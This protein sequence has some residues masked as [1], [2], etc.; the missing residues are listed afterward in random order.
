M[1]INV[2]LTV[3]LLGMI[4]MLVYGQQEISEDC[5]T[6]PN[7]KNPKKCCKMPNIKPPRENVTACVRTIPK[8]TGPPPMRGNHPRSF[9]P[10]QNCISECLF[11]QGGIISDG[12][13][14]KEAATTTLIA[15]V[16]SSSD[17]QT[18]ANTSIETC[19]EKVSSLGNQK[20]RLGCSMIAGSFKECVH[21]MMFTNCPT[22]S[23]T[24]S[25]ECDQLKAHLEKDCPL[26]TLFKAPPPQKTLLG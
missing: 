16:G 3:T 18:V 13:L 7:T 8:P 14:N 11:E 22:E 21:T 12:V 1:S 26:M 15:L 20:D 5:F 2:V 23:W 4:A 17:W 19:F 6:R 9:P 10:R 24:A 25:T